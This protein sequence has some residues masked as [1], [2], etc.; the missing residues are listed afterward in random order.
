VKI[1]DAI[2]QT[3]TSATKSWAAI[4]KKKIRD[5][6][7]GWAAAERYYRG[8]LREPSIKEAAF[9][10]IAEA[11]AK[12]SGGGQYPATARQ[13]MYA[14]RPLIL[15]YTD[16]P[17]GKDFDSY[18]TQALLPEFMRDSPDETA[19]LRRMQ[20]SRSRR[21]RLRHMKPRIA[22]CPRCSPSQ[23]S[24]RVSCP[25]LA[26]CNARGQTCPRTIASPPRRG[27]RG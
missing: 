6:E 21:E 16:K 9:S 7:R 1:G 10:V 20:T 2:H 18:F 12:A 25:P 5:Q 22:S 8:A 26:S 19:S 15:Q 24:A 23:S 17:L 3:V 27:P 13:V 14:A 11:Y 4:E